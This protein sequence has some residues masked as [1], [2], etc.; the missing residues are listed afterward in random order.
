MVEE[1]SSGPFSFLPYY[2]FPL[3]SG[4][5]GTNL[6]WQGGLHRREDLLHD[7]FEIFVKAS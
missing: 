7:Y 3:F 5:L 1:K 6:F 4:S 2:R